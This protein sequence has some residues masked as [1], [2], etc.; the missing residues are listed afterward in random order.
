[1]GYDLDSATYESMSNEPAGIKIMKKKK[2]APRN[3]ESDRPMILFIPLRNNFQD[4]LL[5][6]EGRGRW[7]SKGCMVLEMACHAPP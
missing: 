7:W 5:R 2:K 3:E 6:R 4:V 1:M